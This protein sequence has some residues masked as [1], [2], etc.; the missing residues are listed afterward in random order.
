MKRW[1]GTLIAISFALAACTISVTPNRV[2]VTP[3]AAT[4]EPGASVDLRAS[5]NFDTDSEILWRLGPEDTR[6]PNEVL[7]DRTGPTTT[8]TAPD[9]D[10]TYTVI[11]ET[12][13]EASLRGEAKITVDSFLGAERLDATT[14]RDA[15]VFTSN[16]APGEEQVLGINVSSATVSAGDALIIELDAS[17]DLSVYDEDR[18]PYASSSSPDYFAAGLEAVSS[19]ALDSQGIGVAR[20]CRGSCVIRDAEAGTNF[21]RIT[22]S[23][24]SSVTYT[25]YAYVADY[26]DTG[27]PANDDEATAVDLNDFDQGAIET[28]GDEDYYRLAGSGQVSFSAPSASAEIANGLRAQILDEGGKELAILE[29]GQV[30][31]DRLALRSGDI[32]RVYVEGGERAGAAAVSRYVLELVSTQ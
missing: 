29:P 18:S 24:G 12:V 27:E 22:N 2:E 10:G 31:D 23:G 4:V 16:L 11:A 8:Y 26:D 6:S 5:V 17:L 21:V 14:D 32:I 15:T 7:S 25:L 28:L 9:E 30:S 19:S 3:S 1:L 13:D 20:A